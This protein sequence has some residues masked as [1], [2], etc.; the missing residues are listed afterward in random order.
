MARLD[1]ISNFL[2]GEKNLSAD[3]FSALKSDVG[4]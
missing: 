2:T 1:K 3:D 4:F